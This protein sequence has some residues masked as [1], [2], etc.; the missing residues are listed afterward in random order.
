MAENANVAAE[1]AKAA[2]TNEV[3]KPK[4]SRRGLGSA[5][6]TTRLKFDHSMALP[7]GLFLGH[8]DEVTVKTVTIGEDTSGMPSFN[9]MEVPRLSI[10]F[11]S[12]EEEPNK[13]K[14]ATLSFMAV[15]SNVE[16]IPGGK[17][18]WK[19]AQP[20]DYLKHILEVFVL[21]GRDFTNEELDKLSLSYEDYDEDGNYIPVEPE[22]VIAAWTNLYE[23]FA[24]MMN[25]GRDGNPVYKTK[26]NKN[27]PCFGKL[28]RCVKTK[29]GW[30]NVT[31][32]D[33]AFPAFVGEGVFEIYKQNAKPTIRVDVIKESILPKVADKAAKAPNMPVMPGNT[34]VPMGAGV[35]VD[36][37]GGVYDPM[38]GPGNIGMEAMEDS[39]F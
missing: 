34:G 19:V 21:K 32:G 7:N 17:S 30:N 12:N 11:A 10:V 38:A 6:G 22:V 35:S 25:T 26:D 20:L 36:M 18:E 23:A 15:E 31:N 13:R 24:E 37:T 28:I 33:L 4:V 27:I 2:Q 9:G 16:T 1:S 8:I 3:V 5:R 39:P 14:Y 29:K